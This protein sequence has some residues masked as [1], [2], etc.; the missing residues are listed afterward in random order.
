M[1]PGS[2]QIYLFVPIPLLYD[3]VER[4]ATQMLNSFR[5]AYQLYREAA[6]LECVGYLASWLMSPLFWLPSFSAAL[7][8]PLAGV[9]GFGFPPRPPERIQQ[10]RRSD[11]NAS[12]DVLRANLAAA[13]HSVVGA[14]LP[15]IV[16]GRRVS[17]RSSWAVVLPRSA[18][19]TS[20]K[21]EAFN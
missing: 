6:N 3:R 21:L 5:Y 9:S 8:E 2:C 4:N 18:S 16:T 15:S 12:L 20:S 13:W 10:L 14:N 11:T 19:P 17:G 1:P 7:K